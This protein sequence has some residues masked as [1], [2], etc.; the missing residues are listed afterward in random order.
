MQPHAA[1]RSIRLPMSIAAPT[2]HIL[3][4]A[5]L[6]AIRLETLIDLAERMKHA[7]NDCEHVTGAW[8]E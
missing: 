8:E 6:D 2:R 4:I 5:G 1:A 7:P 3:R